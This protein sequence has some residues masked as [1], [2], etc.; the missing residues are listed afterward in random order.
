MLEEE[1]Y[2]IVMRSPNSCCGDGICG[3]PENE[4]NCPIDCVTMI[5]PPELNNF[6]LSSDTINAGL[7]AVAVIYNLSA[8]SYDNYAGYAVRLILNG[9][10]IHGGELFEDSG[11]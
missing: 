2:R 4:D 3:G 6:G 11:Y 7:N 9:G 10:P 5:N 1:V 8:T